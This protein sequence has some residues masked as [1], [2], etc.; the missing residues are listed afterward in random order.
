MLLPKPFI[1]KKQHEAVRFFPFSLFSF[2]IRSCFLSF[3]GCPKRFPSPEA[4]RSVIRTSWRDRWESS[5]RDKRRIPWAR[6]V[7]IQ[8]DICASADS[9][10]RVCAWSCFQHRFLPASLGSQVWVVEAIDELHNLY[11]WLNIHSFVSV[12]PTQ[13]YHQSSMRRSSFSL[14]GMHPLSLS[15]KSLSLF[16]LTCLILLYLVGT[17]NKTVTTMCWS[18]SLGSLSSYSR[19]WECCWWWRH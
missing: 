18:W 10:H 4:S 15:S 14:G 9:H 16:G 2:S 13:S 17:K 11:S 6:G 7:W 19:P 8:R 12:L 1:L 5:C 3:A